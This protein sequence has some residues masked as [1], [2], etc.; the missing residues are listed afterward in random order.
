M[1]GSGKEGQNCEARRDLDALVEVPD[2]PVDLVPPHKV[3]DAKRDQRPHQP[4]QE[5]IAVFTDHATSAE[6][7]GMGGP[8]AGVGG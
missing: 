8:P 1:M 6:P 2:L 4:C 5:G 3:I 7:G